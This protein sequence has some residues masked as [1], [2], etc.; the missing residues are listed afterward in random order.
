MAYNEALYNQIKSASDLVR[1]LC[2]KFNTLDI[3]KE[4]RE[5][6]EKYARMGMCTI[7]MPKRELQ[8]E[9][10]FPTLLADEFKN[11][12]YKTWGS[13]LV[14]WITHL[15]VKKPNGTPVQFSMTTAAE[16]F[17]R[18]ET[19]YESVAWAAGFEDTDKKIISVKEAGTGWYSQEQEAWEAIKKEVRD[20]D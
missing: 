2:I 9:L 11:I 4:D 1:D 18:W 8:K 19:K 17:S 5:V 15:H 16:Y 12:T 6:L 13:I 10:Y 14:F 20:A 3:P 7:H